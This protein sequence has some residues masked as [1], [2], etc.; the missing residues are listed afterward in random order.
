MSS[1]EGKLIEYPFISLDMFDQ[2]NLSSSVYFLSH[3]HADHIIGLDS[4]VFLQR[5]KDGALLHVSETT[6]RLMKGDERM[7][8][9][10][11]HTVGLPVNQDISLTVSVSC[12][13]YS[14]YFSDLPCN[15]M[16]KLK[17]TLEEHFTINLISA[18]H[19]VGSVMFLIDGRKGPVLYTG[20]FRLKKNEIEKIACF[21]SGSSV[22]R[23]NS[24]Y[25]DTTFCTS[26]TPDLPTRKETADSLCYLVSDWVNTSPLHTVHLKC[27]GKYGYEYIL[28]EVASRLNMRIH[29]NAWRMQF[30]SE[31]RDMED[32]FTDDQHSTQIHS[33]YNPSAPPDCLPCGLSTSQTGEKLEILTI[34]PSSLWFVKNG[35]IPKG[36][37]IFV[38]RQNMWRV[39]HSMHSSYNEIRDFLGYLRPN[40]IYPSV[41]PVDATSKQDA[42]ER[43]KDLEF[44]P[45]MVSSRKT[46]QSQSSYTESSQSVNRVWDS[47]LIQHRGCSDTDE[48]FN[49][50][51]CKGSRRKKRKSKEGAK[52]MQ[53]LAKRTNAKVLGIINNGNE[54]S[55]TNSSNL[56]EL[57]PVEVNPEQNQ[58]DNSDSMSLLEELMGF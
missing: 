45:L 46:E 30:H 36:N 52:S 57:A 9:V 58:E 12:Q 22:R 33:C 29:V 34:V 38:E 19:C 15:E 20:D 26:T 13:E 55:K 18:G 49:S 50:P 51:P 21:N 54:S 47:N 42:Y 48:I 44:C 24:V 43:L 5:L 7:P 41:I 40:R 39:F 16:D 28:K 6:K 17:S 11:K 3:F 1:F 23:I 37:K 8:G 27:K 2:S 35:S 32:Y 4:A 31:L 14:H 53:K 56:E 25:V 10:I